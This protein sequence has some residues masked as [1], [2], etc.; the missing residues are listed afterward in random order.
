MHF[1]ILKSLNHLSFVENMN[2]AR[3]AMNWVSQMVR[4]EM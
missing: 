3:D 2:F 4:N 1:L